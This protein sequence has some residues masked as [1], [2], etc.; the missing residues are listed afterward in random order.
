MIDTLLA[1]IGG[2]LDLVANIIGRRKFVEDRKE[3][4]EDYFAGKKIADKLGLF[5][6][7]NHPM[8]DPIYLA[9]LKNAGTYLTS[10]Q[11]NSESHTIEA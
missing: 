3:R 6:K 11:R 1:E 7:D 9:T 4:I 8:Q 10:Q 5:D 2:N